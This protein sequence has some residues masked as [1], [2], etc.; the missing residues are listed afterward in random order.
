MS[1][2]HRE[3]GPSKTPY[4]VLLKAR[5]RRKRRLDPTLGRGV[6]ASESTKLRSAEQLPARVIASEPDRLRNSPE[7]P[8]LDWDQ[9]MRVAK[10]RLKEKLDVLEGDNN[11][12]IAEMAEELAV[13]ICAYGKLPEEVDRMEA[14]E[15]T[16]GK[17]HN[18]T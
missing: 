14:R 12:A 8:P 15:K 3:L 4:E 18:P 1:R 5:L 6:A 2:K 17:A 11:P 10:A 16:A 13:F 9:A 7:R